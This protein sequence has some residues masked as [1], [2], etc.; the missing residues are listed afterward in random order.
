MSLSAE[1]LASIDEALEAYGKSDEALAEVVTRARAVATALSGDE[2]LAELLDGCEEAVQA[3]RESAKSKLPSRPPPYRPAAPRSTAVGRPAPSDEDDEAEVGSGMV[4]IPEA[5]LREADLPPVLELGDA[6][7]FP[8]DEV[9]AL[10]PGPPSEDLEE[11][12]AD[13]ATSDIHGMSVDEL[14]ADAEPVSAESDP[15]ELAD[16]FDEELALDAPAPDVPTAKLPA[17]PRTVPPPVPADAASK[18]PAL[19]KGLFTEEDDATTVGSIGDLLSSSDDFE[20]L[21]DDDVLEL[22]SSET[23]IPPSLGAPPEEA[24][25]GED[26]KKGGLIS[27]I[28]GRK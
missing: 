27:R 4:E 11:A 13:A 12:F 2:Y 24:A 18:A 16:L 8:S 5:E 7:A 1:N 19:A 3:A 26:E 22:D 23:E 28:L 14:F 10:N 6:N 15:S 25:D 21:V 17:R 9:T 20:L